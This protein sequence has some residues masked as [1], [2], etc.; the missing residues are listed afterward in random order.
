MQGFYTYLV[1][2][3]DT[4]DIKAG[5]TTSP[6]RWGGFVSRGASLYQLHAA[7]P[8]QERDLLGLESDLLSWLGASDLLEPAFH[9]KAQGSRQLGGRGAGYTECFHATCLAFY[10]DALAACIRIMRAHP[11]GRCVSS[12][13]EQ[14][15]GRT[16]GRTYV[17][18]HSPTRPPLVSDAHAHIRQM[19]VDKSEGSA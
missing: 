2:W 4:L 1:G 10:R 6:T 17:D 7:D 13:R 11:T 8:T 12:M 5:V 3:G 15:H 9:Y 18:P 14:M 19:V 16:D